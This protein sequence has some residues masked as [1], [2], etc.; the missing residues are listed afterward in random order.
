LFVS[1]SFPLYLFNKICTAGASLA[2]FG[3]KENLR[4]H[5]EMLCIYIA[6]GSELQHKNVTGVA[7]EQKSPNLALKLEASNIKS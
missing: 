4:Q 7:R 1:I 6:I 3:S 2:V 5:T